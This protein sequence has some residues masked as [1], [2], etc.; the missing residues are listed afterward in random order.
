MTTERV[1][2]KI[3]DLILILPLC[4]RYVCVYIGLKVGIS[5]SGA[6]GRLP[7]GRLQSKVKPFLYMPGEALRVPGR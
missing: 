3:W 7:L 4:E 6:L 1:F 5:K 2:T